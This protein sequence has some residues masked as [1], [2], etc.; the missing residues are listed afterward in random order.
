MRLT[1]SCSHEQQFRMD[2][3]QLI[4]QT[5]FLFFLYFILWSI[6][7]CGWV[8]CVRACVGVENYQHFQLNAIE[9]YMGKWLQLKFLVITA[10]WSATTSF[11][12]LHCKTKSIL[13]AHIYLVT[14][15]TRCENNFIPPKLYALCI[16][17][18]YLYHPL[19]TK[20]FVINLIYSYISHRQNIS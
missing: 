17:Y 7:E 14:A 13:L 3:R 16:V 15:W 4:H 6:Y 11:R 5:Q 10:F 18:L 8:D 1:E 2:E 20:A 9:H 19:G 12:D